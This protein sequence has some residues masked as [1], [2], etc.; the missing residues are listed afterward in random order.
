MTGSPSIYTHTH[1]YVYYVKNMLNSVLFYKY[2]YKYKQFIVVLENIEQ[3][4][5]F[6]C[7]INWNKLYSHCTLKWL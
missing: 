1:I 6:L 5:D 4:Y 2:W 3:N 7:K